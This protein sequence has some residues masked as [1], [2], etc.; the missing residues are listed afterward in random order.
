M[1][2][3]DALRDAGLDG[4]QAAQALSPP[5][6]RVTTVEPVDEA[7]EERGGFAFVAVLLLYGQLISMGY[8]VA[9][10]VVEEKSS[11]VVEL[12]LS[13]L[14]PRIC[15][16]ARS[17]ASACSACPAAPARVVGLAA[18]GLGG[19]LDVTGDVIVAAGLALSGSSSATRSTRR[20]SPARH[21]SCRARR[22]C[23][24]CSGR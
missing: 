22:T 13:T 9:M 3:A 5:Q 2:S 21:R 10:G 19:A 14:R 6:L 15:S 24:R 23:N 8:F 18:A 4:R 7:A 20:R 12:L 16:R 17:S 1:R 11:R